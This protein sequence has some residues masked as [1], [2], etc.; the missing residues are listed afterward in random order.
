MSS[1]LQQLAQPFDKR[2]IE[3]KP[4][5]RGGDYVTH[6]VVTEYLLKIVGPFDYEL[7]QVIRGHAPEVKTKSTTYGAREE[8]ILGVVARLTITVDGQTRR[9][10]EVGTED[11]P[12]MQTDAANLKN[13]MSDALKRCAMRFG[14]GLHLWSQE[15][16]E[17]DQ[18]DGQAGEAAKPAVKPQVKTLGAAKG[19]DLGK[20]LSDRGVEKPLE[21]A[22]LMAN[23]DDLVSLEAL[24][25]PEAKAVFQ[26][27][28]GGTPEEVPA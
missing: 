7:V 28:E 10:E 14:L 19:A 11:N 27:A 20:A 23:R 1:Q 25:I 17:L 18:V 6:S 13:A 26:A 15:M 3:K 9:V 22:R 5:A 4:G 12:A 2:F 16:Y 21:F 24:T 8:A